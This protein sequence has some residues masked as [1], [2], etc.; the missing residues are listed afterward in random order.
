MKKT[1]IAI[2]VIASFASC[3]KKAD[4]SRIERLDYNQYLTEQKKKEIKA[5]ANEEVK[6]L[7]GKIEES[8]KNFR[9]GLS[10]REENI[11]YAGNSSGSRMQDE[12]NRRIIWMNSIDRSPS[13]SYYAEQARATYI[14]PYGNIR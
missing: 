4:L 3:Q 7:I 1:F 5:P 12:I 2:L 6:E 11:D 8:D 10:R 14:N 9:E 13:G